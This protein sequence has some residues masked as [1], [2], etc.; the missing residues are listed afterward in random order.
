MGAFGAEAFMSPMRGG[1]F[2]V[3]NSKIDHQKLA[4]V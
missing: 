3:N 4:V 1:T 2:S